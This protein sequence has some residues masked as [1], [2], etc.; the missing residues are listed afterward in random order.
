MWK[1][2][3]RF[4]CVES[5]L[6]LRQMSGHYRKMDF[7]SMYRSLSAE[8]W[9]FHNWDFPFWAWMTIFQ[10]W[11]WIKDWTIQLLWLFPTLRFHPVVMEFNAIRQPFWPILCGSHFTGQSRSYANTQKTFCLHQMC[12]VYMTDQEY[13]TKRAILKT[14]SLS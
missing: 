8:S 13:L 1:I 10:A 11:C 2:K 12:F 14:F 3:L 5:Y 9:S 4:L 7:G 6:E